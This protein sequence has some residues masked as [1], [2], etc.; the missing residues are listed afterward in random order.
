MTKFFKITFTFLALG[1]VSSC[2]Q[3]LQSVNLK[4]N[5]EDSAVQ[6]EFNVVKKTLTVEEARAQTDAPYTRTVMQ[7][8]RG[9]DAQPILEETAL[10]S[11]FPKNNSQPEYSI[12]V[13]DEITFSRLVENNQQVF[14]VQEKWPAKK[15]ISNYKL[16]IGDTVTLTLVKDAEILMTPLNRNNSDGNSE[17]Q[18]LIINSQQD[19]KTINSTGRIGSDGS[20]LL[21][22]VGRLEASGKSLNEL[23]S[24]VRNILI[25]NGVSP[26]FQ[27][28]IV[29]FKSQ[30]SYLTINSTST[31][32]L[33]DQ[34][35]TLRDTNCINVG[36]KPGI[37]TQIKL[38]RNGE[39]FFI[40]LRDIYGENALDID[41][42]SR[43]TSS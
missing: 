22:E 43:I 36:F 28:E 29:E 10:L 12:G 8:G 41:I 11:E 1:L 30:K 15:I 9:K 4:I 25:R 37:I 27:L 13:G 31:V 16:G 5:T 38:Q 32:I 42:Q 19:E 35:K 20:V 34:R 24:E 40:L 18:N 39:E 26:K 21:L 14:K 7:S 2:S 3:V 6:E 33:D 23:R 17:T